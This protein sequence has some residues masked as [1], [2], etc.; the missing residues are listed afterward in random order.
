MNK[1]LMLVICDFL[2]LS[3]LAL[4][5]FD[6]PEE[7][8]TPTIDA[9]AESTSSE[10]ELIDLLEESLKSEQNSRDNLREDLDKTRQSLEEKARVLAKQAAELKATEQA[11][12]AKQSE[13]ARLSATKSELESE[14]AQLEAQ[15]ATLAAEQT[16]LNNQFQATRAQLDEL[17]SERVALTQNLGTLQAEASTTKERLSVAEQTLIAREIALAEREAELKAAQ[18]AAEKLAAEQQALTQKLVAAETERT[19]LRQNLANEQAEKAQL[20]SEKEAAFARAE[21]LGENVSTLGQNVSQLGAGV[22]TIAQTSEDIKKEIIES[23]PLTMSQI[24]TLFQENR[25]EITF[26]T[27]ERNLFGNISQN[28]YTAKSIL[29]QD[30][31][32][33]YFIVAHTA[34]T[35]FK[36]S[37][38]STPESVTLNVKMAGRSFPSTQFGI[39]AS[40]PRILFIPIPPEYVSA[41]KLDTF[42]LSQQP[43]RWEEAVLIKN[44]ETNFGRTEFRRLP[45]NAA[46]LKVDRPILGESFADFAS[47]KGDLAFT[48]NAQFIGVMVD[49]KHALVIDDFLASAIIKVGASYDASQT[50][51]TMDRLQDRLRKLPAELQ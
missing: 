25:V 5:R 1:T 28:T 46:F 31:N 32:G 35:P 15:K 41:S 14:K 40:D 12:E 27:T 38:S 29:I 33:G 49:T 21:R 47:S 2:L 19:L 6:P 30:T 16:Q 10:E 18:E 39:L 11:L 20:Q 42:K 51:T 36:L 43:E 48:K 13:A 7:K 26:S 45:S 37:R 23:R 24:F 34:D 44:D 9:T 50:A 17:Q 22:T 3:M 4:A 8:P